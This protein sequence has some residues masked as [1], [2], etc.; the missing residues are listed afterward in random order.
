MVIHGILQFLVF[1][2]FYIFYHIKDATNNLI[3]SIF[4]FTK[5]TSLFDIY[6][7]SPRFWKCLVRQEE[8]KEV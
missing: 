7:N 4:P 3:L 2:I 5:V 1:F 8:V 6:H